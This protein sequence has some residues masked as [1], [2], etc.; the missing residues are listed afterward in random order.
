MIVNKAR[1]VLLLRQFSEITPLSKA[2]RH[3]PVSLLQVGTHLLSLELGLAVDSL[4][5]V[6]ETVIDRVDLIQVCVLYWKRF[7]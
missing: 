3:L 7:L 6:L 4:Q 1:I 2:H 5:H